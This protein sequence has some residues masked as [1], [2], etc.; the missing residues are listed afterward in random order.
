MRFVVLQTALKLYVYA[1]Q[2]PETWSVIL[3]PTAN[4]RK[5]TQRWELL[6]AQLK[7]NQIPFQLFQTTQSGDGTTIAL[8]CLK[9]G[10]RSILIVGGDGSV[11]EVVH[12]ILD[13][14]EIPSHLIKLAIYPAGTGNDFVRTFKIPSEP[15]AFVKMM[16]QSKFQIQ[17]AGS[18]QYLDTQKPLQYFINVA[19][20]GFDAFVAYTANVAKKK[21]KSGVLTYLI[22][23]ISSLSKYEAVECVVEI[24]D[25]KSTFPVFAILAG[26]GKYAG[27]GM[28][29]V[30][31][32]I[33][34]DGLFHVTAVLKI[35][36]AK[37]IRNIAKL[38][39]GAFK[40]LEEV[41]ITTAKVVR[42]YPSK[43]LYVE[44]DGESFGYGPVEFRIL[45][46]RIQ[47][48]IP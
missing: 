2:H 12:A 48:L 45:P 31:D 22:A 27:N 9:N 39:T 43:K 29:L 14:T 23:L 34:N 13:Q 26:I 15:K 46:E 21:G 33:P 11:N 41:K 42:V 32:A 20:I 24:D 19:G 44:A 8:Q 5:S 17:D 4:G 40:H 7:A 30:P 3:N 6:E 16:L 36:K 18:I 10:S 38:F 47:M 28:K 25:E 35:G 37:V 1:M